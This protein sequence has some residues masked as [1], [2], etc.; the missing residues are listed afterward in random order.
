ML[1][2]VQCLI[3]GNQT[4][5]SYYLDMEEL[6]NKLIQRWWKPFWD[7]AIKIGYDW[8]ETRYWYWAISYLYRDSYIDDDWDEVEYE[9]W[10]R[11]FNLRE[12][13]SK[14][15]WLWQFVCQNEL[16]PPYIQHRWF[17]DRPENWLQI[18]D[19]R[20]WLIE[21]ALRGALELERFLLDN[22]KVS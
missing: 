22:I 6:L 17:R 5:N 10:R 16:Y 21:S 20:Y 3:Y 18:H 19:Y 15:S 9:E 13:V 8:M 14:E 11:Q 7:N 2:Y 12:L 4:F 1:L